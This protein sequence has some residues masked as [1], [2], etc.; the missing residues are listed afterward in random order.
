[1]AVL[2][3]FPE[4]RVKTPYENSLASR[5]LAQPDK[6]QFQNYIGVF[7]LSEQLNLRFRLPEIPFSEYTALLFYTLFSII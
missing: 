4:S 6:S 3:F 1:M 7:W 5:D 2:K